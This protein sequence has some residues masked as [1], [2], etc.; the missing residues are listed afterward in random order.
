MMILDEAWREVAQTNKKYDSKNGEYE[1]I[2][3]QLEIC[4]QNFREKN[5]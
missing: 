5:D 1:T 4:R 3:Q 2:R